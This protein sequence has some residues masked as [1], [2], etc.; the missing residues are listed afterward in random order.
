[1][2]DQLTQRS[3]SALGWGYAGYATRAAVGFASGLVLARLL[4]PK[5]FGQVAAAS[6]VFQFANQLADGG[7]NLALVQAAELDEYGIRFGFTFQ[8]LVGI[9]LTVSCVLLAP[10]VATAF[11]DPAITDVLRVT[12]LL[13]I[14]QALGQ[15]SAALLKRQLAFR[16]LQTIQIG[17]YLLG[18]V[19]VGVAAAM[20]GWGVWSLIAAQMVQSVSFSLMAFIQAP[21]SL[22]P[23]F[24]KRSLTLVRFGIKVTGANI[25]NWS[26]SNFD[27]AV[28]GRSFGSAALGLY[29][30]AF[31]T[32]SSPADAV[33]GTWQQVLF[34]GCSRAGGRKP[35]LRRAYLASISAITLITLPIFWSVAVIAPTVVAVLYGHLWT[36]IVPLL[37]PLA[38]AITVNAT[39]ALAGP[40]LGS[41]DLVKYELRAQFISLVV[42]VAAFLVA[43]RYSMTVLAWIVLGV[44]FVRLAVVTQPTLQLLNLR[45]IHVFRAAR[46]SIALACFTAL[47]VFGSDRA[48]SGWGHTGPV[49][50]LI[51]SILCGAI[52]A[53]GTFVCAGDRIL[54][55]EL[56]AFLIQVSG[57][58]PSRL[59]RKLEQIAAKQAM[60]SGIAGLKTDEA[61]SENSSRSTRLFVATMMTPSGDTGVQTH[62]AEFR[63]E[64]NNSGFATEL[65]TPQSAPRAAWFF[66]HAIG[67]VVG[68]LHLRKA[69]LYTWIH[70]DQFLLRS[71]MRRHLPP[72][73]PWTIY[74]Q[75]PRSA[76]AGMGLRRL[77][78]QTVVMMVHFNRSQGEEMSDRGWIK[79][80][81]M[82]DREARAIERQTL[83]GVDRV[84][85]CS[86]FMRSFLTSTIP[87]LAFRPHVVIPNFVQ[88]PLPA[89]DGPSGDVITIGTIEPRK[90]QQA[91]LRMLAEARKRGRAYTLTIVGTGE[92]HAE[93]QALANELGIG[94]LVVFAGYVHNASC[95]LHRHRLYVQAAKMENMP[96]VLLE[97]FSAGLPVMAPAVGGIPEILAD[98]AEGYFWDPDD[99]PAG[100]ERLISILDNERLRRVMGANALA[101]YDARFRSD[102]VAQLLYRFVTG[103]E[104][105]ANEELSS[106]CHVS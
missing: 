15:V 75:C 10:H 2:S 74:A 40:I 44:Y 76:L 3:F 97:A 5:P 82:I 16:R 86:G 42:A 12:S 59:A 43:A 57:S 1:M 66:T 80:G 71:A 14:L 47:A 56:V 28:V 105:W 84:V 70:I 99:A 21:Y 79:K 100:A 38:I 36:G 69:R 22:K 88:R 26:L 98:G 94:D 45:W 102:H 32:V 68:L 60:R 19:L 34:A 33:V 63:R 17:S 46:G 6:L 49:T 39:M 13:F 8:M 77:P 51:I 106:A 52:T 89:E 29:S 23:Y 92:L 37:P 81:G 67:R 95:L 20:R 62:F 31:N 61:A 90:N 48:T 9:I 104:S 18:Y 11:N 53:A 72:N 4:G 50:S 101:T 58:L 91:I 78:S 24:T 83:L 54:S 30:R 41:V 73:S 25:L 27:N 55:Q 85:Y 93:M 64:L 103:N 35:A 87:G 7:L 96:I 65:L